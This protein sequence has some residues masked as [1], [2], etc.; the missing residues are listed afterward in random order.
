MHD[1]HR[2]VVIAVVAM[3]VMQAPVNDVAGVVAVRNGF[4]TT[5][6]AMNVLG[7]VS[8][9]CWPVYVWVL[10][11]HR[12]HVF[13]NGAVFPLMVQVA[14]VC[15]I[16]MII[17]FETHVPAIWTVRMRMR[18]GMCYVHGYLLS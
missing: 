3:R 18:L 6:G 12:E 5:A 16:H 15:V 11:R 17:M 2:T 14:V 10:I 7:A 4:V 8:V 9:F 1:L 13:F